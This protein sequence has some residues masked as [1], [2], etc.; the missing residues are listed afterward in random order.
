MNAPAKVQFPIYRIIVGWGIVILLLWA[1]A[2][3]R[4]GHQTLFYLVILTVFLLVVI[5]YKALTG[6]VGPAVKGATL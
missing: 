4:L 3:N 6:L 2:K 1:V 5:N